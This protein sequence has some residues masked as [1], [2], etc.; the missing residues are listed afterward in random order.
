[1]LYSD[2]AWCAPTN[3]QS[4]WMTM[5]AGSE[6]TIFGLVVQKRYDA[7]DTINQYIT[8][9]TL[10]Y[11]DDANTWTDVESGRVFETGIQEEDD[12]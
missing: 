12:E 6:T 7:T 4:Q 1:M 2:L 9:F 3:D 5:D 8:S 11:S 10:A